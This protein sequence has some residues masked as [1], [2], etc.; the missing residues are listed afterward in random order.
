MDLIIV[1]PDAKSADILEHFAKS[2]GYRALIQDPADKDGLIANPTNH[3]DY[4]KNVLKSFIL[5]NAKGNYV[6]KKQE[7]SKAESDSEAATKFDFE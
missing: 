4:S 7:A 6:K 1:L 3:E 5:Q 2:A